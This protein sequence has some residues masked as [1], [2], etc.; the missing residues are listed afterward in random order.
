MCCPVA[1]EGRVAGVAVRLSKD[2]VRGIFIGTVSTQTDDRTTLA[3]LRSA[4][5][6]LLS[7]VARRAATGTF[8]W[9]RAVVLALLLAALPASLAQAGDATRFYD[10]SGRYQGRASMNTANPKQKSLYDPQGR[11]LGRV[12]TDKSGNARLYDK[13]GRFLGHTTKSPAQ[14]APPQ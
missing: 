4:L 2:K 9:L 10:A 6:V 14:P 3:W 1:G 13:Q 12:M 8:V 11:Y 7:S 5:L